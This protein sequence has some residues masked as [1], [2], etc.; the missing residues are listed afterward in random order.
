MFIIWFCALFLH[1]VCMLVKTL[2][3]QCS[4]GCHYNY[5]IKLLAVLSVWNRKVVYILWMH[6]IEKDGNETNNTAAVLANKR[7]EFLKLIF[8]VAKSWMELMTT[9]KILGWSCLTG[10]TLARIVKYQSLQGIA[11]FCYHEIIFLLSLFYSLHTSQNNCQVLDWWVVLTI[12][13]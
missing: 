2:S 8:T 7:P 12:P 3:W 1:A 6:G 13:I 11:F 10:L 9:S 5:F 4:F